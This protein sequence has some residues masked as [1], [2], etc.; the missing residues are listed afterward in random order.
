LV[1]EFA[2]ISRRNAAVARPVQVRT[3]S[4]QKQAIALAQDTVVRI[5]EQQQI[6]GGAIVKEARQM[7]AYCQKIFVYAEFDGVEAAHESYPEGCCAVRSHRWS[8]RLAAS[9]AG[10]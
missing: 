10:R 5:I 9:S 4:T 1:N 6:I 2:N 7:I 8:A 3:G